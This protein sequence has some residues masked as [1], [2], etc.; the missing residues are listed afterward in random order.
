MLTYESTRQG[1][2]AEVKPNALKSL[3]DFNNLTYRDAAVLTGVSVG[4]ISNIVSRR[5][6][7][8]N[9]VTAGK[10]AKGFKVPTET[11]FELIQTV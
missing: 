5:R 4:T 3:M 2:A 8:V 7:T 10:I 6:T 9:P 1:F 11:L